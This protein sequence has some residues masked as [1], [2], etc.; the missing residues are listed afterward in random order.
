MYI[1][2]A[3]PKR[4]TAFPVYA[5]DHL[6]P[7][8]GDA[9]RDR[10]AIITCLNDDDSVFRI[11][12]CAAFGAHENSYRICGVKGQIENLRDHT[13]RVQLSYNEWDVPEGAKRLS[14]YVADWE[15]EEKEKIESTG[16][17]GSDY[18]VLREFFRCIER[19]ERPVLDV[20]CATTM[21]SVAILAHRS[22][23]EGGAPYDIP[24]FRREEDRKKYEHDTLSPFYGIDGSEP[25]LPCALH[26]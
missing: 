3:Y 25:T 8:M 17:G 20:Y 23:L 7:L 21:A 4:V 1:T 9:V 16:H 15:D 24:D 18:L 26:S 5:P 10:A 12:G 2:G 13:D 14:C 11:T 22:I 19:N 6:D